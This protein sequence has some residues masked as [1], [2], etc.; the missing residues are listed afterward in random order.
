R[1]PDRVRARRRRGDAGARRDELHRVRKLHL[2]LSREA[3]HHPDHAPEQGRDQKGGE[4]QMNQ[5]IVTSSPHITSKRTTSGIM[6][7]VILA[8]VPA[9]IAAYIHF[10]YRALLLI[11]VCVACCV[12]SEA[13]YCALLKKPVPVGDLSAVVTGILLG[14]NLPATLP[15]WQAVVG[16][17]VSIV[18]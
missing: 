13:L 2:C 10:G 7:D 8:M 18:V 12:A 3:D 16:S 6:L 17:V 9:I 1:D 15:V 4:Q 5:L 11:A 14:F